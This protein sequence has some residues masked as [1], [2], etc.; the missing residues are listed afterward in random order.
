MLSSRESGDLLQV[1]QATTLKVEWKSSFN[2]ANAPFP[3][4][5]WCCRTFF[6]LP[7]VLSHAENHA[8]TNLAPI[9]WQKNPH[10]SDHPSRF[11][12]PLL[13][14]K[15]TASL[16]FFSL[17]SIVCPFFLF[18]SFPSSLVPYQHGK[19]THQPGKWSFF[20]LITRLH[21]SFLDHFFSFSW[22][23]PHFLSTYMLHPL[24]FHLPKPRLLNLLPIIILLTPLTTFIMLIFF[25]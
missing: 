10:L 12:P 20:P 22:T 17:S 4:S 1:L 23:Q 18:F 14:L 5:Q 9:Y 6:T 21:S 15:I 3:L 13:S 16:V 2:G 7:I 24:S 8:A 11:S 19:T 25:P